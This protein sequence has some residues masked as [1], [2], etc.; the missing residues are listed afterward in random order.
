[1]KHTTQLHTHARIQ[2][3][4]Y[5]LERCCCC[6]RCDIVCVSFL[7][8]PANDTAST[9]STSKFYSC[10][11]LRLVFPSTW[12]GGPEGKRDREKEIEAKK[13]VRMGH[14]RCC[15]HF[16]ILLLIVTTALR[17]TA[18]ERTDGHST[19]NSK[20]AIE[21]ACNC[22]FRTTEFWEYVG[23]TSVILGEP[24]IVH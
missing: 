22:Y 1:M 12:W 4:S 14:R 23:I 19:W 11:H 18:D 8:P 20:K 6:Y 16:C 17:M 9:W 10:H 24:V 15:E 2:Y 13:C 21:T 3:L 7:L 5:T